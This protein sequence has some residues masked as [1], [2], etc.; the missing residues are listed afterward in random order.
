MSLD[1]SSSPTLAG[2]ML[3]HRPEASNDEGAKGWMHSPHVCG[4]TPRVRRQRSSMHEIFPN[5]ERQGEDKFP[6]G[7]VGW[8][9]P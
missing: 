9:G 2:A 1:H 5:S 8:P 7:N 4:S 6:P 3:G